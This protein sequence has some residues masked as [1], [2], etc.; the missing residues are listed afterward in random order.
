MTLLEIWDNDL[1]DLDY[2]S[3]PSSGLSEFLISLPSSSGPT[4]KTRASRR[5]FAPEEDRRARLDE[6]GSGRWSRL[7]NSALPARLPAPGLRSVLRR[8]ARLAAFDAYAAPRRG[9]AEDS[10]GFYRRC[11]GALRPGRPLGLARPWPLLR[12]E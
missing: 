3:A 9:L 11:N 8:D 10:G 7:A 5:E 4:N 2:N 12:H 1:W 6:Y